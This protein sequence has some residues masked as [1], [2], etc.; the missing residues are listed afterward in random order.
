MNHGYESTLA[1][2]EASLARLQLSY[3]D[4]YLVHSPRG[5]KIVETWDAL[6]ALRSSGKVRSIGVS[7]FDID[8]LKAL[9][10]RGR[11]LPA[12]NQFEMHP[13]VYHVRRDL[14]EYCQDRG[15]V[16]Q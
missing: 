12:V 6:S 5:G 11:D 8:H 13:L 3:V 10:S 2:F 9:E 15:I 1:A 7:N 4:L 14:V 16:V